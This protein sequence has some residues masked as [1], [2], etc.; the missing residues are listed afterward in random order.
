MT[1]TEWLAERRKSI[2]GS[3]AATIL[4]MNPYRSRYNLWLEKTGGLFP[5]EIC[6][7]ESVRLG[8]DLEEYVATSAKMLSLGRPYFFVRM[9]QALLKSDCVKSPS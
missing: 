5:D 2:G 9:V 1:R 7:R 4:G 6:D 8:N 3:D